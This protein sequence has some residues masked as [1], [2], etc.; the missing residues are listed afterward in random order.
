[1]QIQSLDKL[2]VE[3]NIPELEKLE[4]PALAK[5]GPNAFR[6]LQGG[7]YSVGQLGWHA[8]ELKRIGSNEVDI[9]F[10]TP[11]TCE[12][13]G[14][15]VFRWDGANFTK[16]IPEAETFGIRVLHHAFTARF[17]P[18]RKWAEFDDKARFQQTGAQTEFE[19]RLGENYSLLSVKD[20]AGRPV[21]FNAVG[22]VI[23]IRAPKAKGAFDYTLYYA[24]YVD[25]PRYAGSISAQEILLAQDY[26]YPTVGRQPAPYA[27]TSYTPKGWKVIGQGVLDS[28]V[29]SGDLTVSKF[30]MDLPVVYYSFSSAPFMAVSDQVGKWQIST[31]GLG[32]APDRLHAENV[33]QGD[34]VA[35]YNETLS[36]Y[37]FPSW[38]TVV[39]PSYG[40]GALEAYSYATYGFFPA[41]DAHEPSHT[42]WGGILPNSYLKSQWNESFAVYCEG[43][44]QREESLGNRDERRKAFVSECLPQASFNDAS[45]AEGSPELGL[46]AGSLGYG[47]GAMVLQMLENELGTPTFLRCIHAFLA[48]RKPGELVEWTDFEAAVNRATSQDYGWFFRQWLQRPGWP[49][50]VIENIRYRNGVVS[51]SVNF[52]GKPYRLTVEVLIRF[53]GGSETKRVV[54]GGTGEL[55]IPVSKKPLLVSFDP[56]RRLLRTYHSDETP[57]DLHSIMH[58][59]RRYVEPAHA[60]WGQVVGGSTLSELPDDLN[61]VVIVGSPESMPALK[62]L[63]HQVGFEVSGNRVTYRG[64]SVDLDKGAAFAVV[65]LPGGGHCCLAMGKSIFDPNFGRSRV[66]IVDEYGRFLRGST[67]PKTSGWLT[68]RL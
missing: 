36:P 27:L 7:S 16:Y 6:F 43:L 19:F 42:W 9:V 65:D 49:N 41:E 31:Y 8:Y 62:P 53:V 21:S 33:V 63:F 30:R 10:S 56:W 14:E 3:R 67:E 34:V 39:T 44:F 38:S 11:L 15:Q 47:K 4:S 12:D 50:L 23:S 26:W 61:G 52:R 64:T 45:I 48:A 1:M 58:S 37:P 18:N 68:A 17:Q 2:A 32:I 22:G 28:Q 54:I 5:S 51:A 60:D 24:G 20:G 57:Y 25:H 35:F 46:A 40:G 66:C 13:L 29:D 59:S 55:R